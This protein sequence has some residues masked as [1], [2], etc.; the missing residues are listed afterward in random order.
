[1]PNIIN[2]NPG[3]FTYGNAT[4][5]KDIFVCSNFPTASMVQ[6]CTVALCVRDTVQDSQNETLL[7]FAQNNAATPGLLIQT[8]RANTAP[9]PDAGGTWYITIS[10]N[11]MIAP[12]TMGHY[13]SDICLMRFW[14]IGG[15]EYG[16]IWLNGA[17]M[18]DTSLAGYVNLSQVVGGS[19]V[20]GNL[21]VG[22]NPNGGVYGWQ[23][24]IG[25]IIFWNTNLSDDECSAFNTMALTKY[26][27]NGGLNINLDGAS[28]ACG[29]GSSQGSNII[30]LLHAAL[31]NALITTTALGSQGSAYVT[32]NLPNWISSKNGLPVSTLDFLF[33]DILF[34]DFHNIGLTIQQTETNVIL[35]CN[36]VQAAGVPFVLCTPTS[37]LIIDTNAA[38]TRTTYTTWI[39]QN[40]KAL[41][42]ANICDFSLDPNVGLIGAY[43]NYP[44]GDGLHPGAT[45]CV[46]MVN[47][48]L[49]VIRSVEFT[50]ASVSLTNTLTVTSA[51]VTNSTSFT[52]L[53]TITAGTALS[54]KDQNGQGIST[55]VLGDTVPLK[56]GWR[57]TGTTVTAQCYQF[58]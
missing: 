16:K 5:N 10:N 20:T 7:C 12:Q 9:N 46:S 26:G 33:A 53:L 23:G 51:G 41:G 36:Q 35:Y 50:G 39:Q 57:F 18:P 25:D 29:N 38:A 40:W 55:P 31:P 19:G 42:A 2:G 11:A 30:Q 32:N 43:S 15:T 4:G 6:N 56:P 47:D 1:M 34:N 24:G 37:A 45:D 14:N 49:P 27:M 58:P 48:M 17:I 52:Y 13:S 21:Y 22:A 44:D 3:V 8:Y 54:L 28:I